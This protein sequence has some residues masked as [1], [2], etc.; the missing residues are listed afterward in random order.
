M[1]EVCNISNEN[2]P[3]NNLAKYQYFYTRDF[4]S[5]LHFKKELAFSISKIFETSTFTT[6]SLLLT[7]KRFAIVQINTDFVINQLEKCFYTRQLT[8]LHHSNKTFAL[9][10]A[11]RFSKHPLFTNFHYF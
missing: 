3:P 1:D 10:I 8:L 2:R 7:V 4:I 5:F 6:F 9:S 11:K